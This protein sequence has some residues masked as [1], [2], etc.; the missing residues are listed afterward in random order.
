MTNRR[1]KNNQ[2][3][4]SRK[5]TQMEKETPDSIKVELRYKALAHLLV[6]VYPDIKLLGSEQFQSI[7]KD[8]DYLIRKVRWIN[9]D[10]QK[11][12]KKE[13]SEEYLIQ[14]LS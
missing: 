10:Y 8:A 1:S 12:L 13:L 3:M 5:I 9:E 6:Q 2:I 14:L 11:P 4:W 7:L